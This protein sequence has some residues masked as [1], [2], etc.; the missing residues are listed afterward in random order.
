MA[1]SFGRWRPKHLLAA[2][3]TYWAGLGIATLG[4]AAATAWRITRNPGG[5]IAAGYENGLAHLTMTEAGATVWRSTTELSTIALWLAVPPLLLWL[6]WMMF[7]KRE[8]DADALAR[9][10]TSPA[11]GAPDPLAFRS[12][13]TPDR[14]VER[15]RDAD[16]DRGR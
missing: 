12:P 7:S 13:T 3:T 6:L 15:A 2:W 8:R 14:A 11:L 10:R 1:L 4:P 9:G 16:R 5:T